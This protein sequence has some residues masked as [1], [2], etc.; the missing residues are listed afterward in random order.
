MSEFLR[1]QAQQQFAL[2]QGHHH[3]LGARTVVTNQHIVGQAT[4]AFSPS[5]HVQLF[6]CPRSNG[7]Q[8]R[9]QLVDDEARLSRFAGMVPVDIVERPVTV[10]LRLLLPE[11][12]RGGTSFFLLGGHV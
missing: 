6:C 1:Q 7:S 4:R 11:F 2:A 12:Q 9:Q 5:I 3:Q 10:Q 8:L